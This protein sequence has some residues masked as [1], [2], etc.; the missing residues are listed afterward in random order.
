MR[1]LILVV[2]MS[3]VFHISAVNVTFSSDGKK[4]SKYVQP[5]STQIFTR[6]SMALDSTN[7]TTMHLSGSIDERIVFVGNWEYSDSLGTNET[8]IPFSGTTQ[9][10]R[11]G[12]L[13]FHIRCTTTPPD[14]L[15]IKARIQGTK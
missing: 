2:V 4:F 11:N 14:S 6:D 7:Q 12:S 10:L 5:G 9:S 15:T 1:R 3:A 13:E 8:W